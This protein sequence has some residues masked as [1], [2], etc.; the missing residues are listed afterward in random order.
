M[1]CQLRRGRAKTTKAL[2]N[3]S[4]KSDIEN[5]VYIAVVAPSTPRSKR[6]GKKLHPKDQIVLIKNRAIAK[7]K[8]E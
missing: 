2:E 4:Y 1:I 5:T 8:A 7:K 3:N 6:T